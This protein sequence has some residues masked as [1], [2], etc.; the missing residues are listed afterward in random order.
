MMLILINTLQA[1]PHSRSGSNDF[2]SIS[3]TARFLKYIEHQHHPNPNDQS[4]K[5]EMNMMCFSN[6]L[7]RRIESLW[8]EVGIPYA[9]R[10]YYREALCSNSWRSLEKFHEL[11]KYYELLLKHRSL[12]LSVMDAITYRENAWKNLL[13]FIE[14]Q[15]TRLNQMGFVD[16]ESAGNQLVTSYC[17][18]EIE[19]LLSQLQQCTLQVVIEIQKWRSICWRPHGFRWKNE[20][21]L[22]RIQRDAIKLMDHSFL[23]GLL[24]FIPIDYSSFPLVFLKSVTDADERISMAVRVVCEEEKLQRALTAELDALQCQG[25]FIPT[26]RMDVS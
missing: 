1:I 8:Q 12:T 7:I 5:P 3:E 22:L 25:V 24:T 9:D 2:P 23:R 17:K 15:Q 11:S 14:S 10:K 21:Y 18:M 26:L 16:V 20:N 4:T 19:S 13:F 6:L